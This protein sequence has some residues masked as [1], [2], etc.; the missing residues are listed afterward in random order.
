MANPGTILWIDAVCINQ[1]NL[2]EKAT[3]VGVMRDVYSNAESTRVWL[4]PRSEDS[5]LAISFTEELLS[6]LPEFQTGKI[7]RVTS[8][9]AMKYPEG[10]PEWVALAHFA[11]TAMV[12]SHLGYSR[13]SFGHS[14]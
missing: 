11:G 5:D 8:D 14:C 3:K 2:D 10:A 1:E 4:R 13:S 9:Y 7:E 6:I 12:H